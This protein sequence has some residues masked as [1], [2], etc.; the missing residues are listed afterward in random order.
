MFSK[1]SNYNKMYNSKK[2]LN[3][4]NIMS[5]GSGMNSL[6]NLGLDIFF[7]QAQTVLIP[8]IDELPFEENQKALAISLLSSQANKQALKTFI[9][10]FLKNI[11][12]ITIPTNDGKKVLQFNS[13]ANMYLA[14][15]EIKEGNIAMSTLLQEFLDFCLKCR[16]LGAYCK[17]TYLACA[18]RRNSEPHGPDGFCRDDCPSMQIH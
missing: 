2:K 5:G 9:L 12:H 7:S 13:P 10:S 4:R 16:R 6:I 15:L 11:Q 18:E 17:T 3:K 8:M 1:K 14:F